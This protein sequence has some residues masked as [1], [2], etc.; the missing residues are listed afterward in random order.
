MK[1]VFYRAAAVSLCALL[2]LTA[3]VACKQKN[4]NVADTSDNAD[5]VTTATPRP[6]LPLENIPPLNDK[7]N[8][9]SG[10]SLA[11]YTVEQLNQMWGYA[12]AELFGERGYV[13]ELPNDYDYVIAY[14]DEEYY[15]TETV[16]FSVMKA[17][18][19]SVSDSIVT[20]TPAEGEKELSTVESFTLP[21]SAFGEAVQD[22]LTEGATVYITYDGT[23]TEDGS[24]SG[25]TYAGIV[26]PSSRF[27]RF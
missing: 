16:F 25:V 7:L 4:P 10:D 6:V 15:V 23:F 14:F 5:E 27:A 24:L 8:G 2:C 22:N 20:V 26:P 17:S 13:W 18:V 3:M 9:S 21:L 1:S 12:V 19:L 11:G